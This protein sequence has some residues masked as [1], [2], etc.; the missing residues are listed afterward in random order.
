MTMPIACLSLSALRTCVSGVPRKYHSP[1][2]RALITRLAQTQLRGSVGALKA[3]RVST[4]TCARRAMVVRAEAAEEKKE[5]EKE[6]NYN[7][8]FGYS[9]KD[10]LLLGGG[11]LFAGFGS[12]WGMLASGVDMV[13]AG[14]I[15]LIVFTLG[16]MLA[17]TASYVFRVANKDMTY[18][19]QLKDY[20][21]AVMAKRLE[22]MP[23]SEL[24]ALM[25][26]LEEK[27]KPKKSL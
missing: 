5:V 26:E 22:E 25:T 3:Q 1:N 24:E 8:Q 17:W 11:L 10:V 9:R 6:V 13:L 20:E 15:E 23:E 12:Y 4:S 27:P 16:T 14:N 21:Q 7:K 19:K 2:A 18:V